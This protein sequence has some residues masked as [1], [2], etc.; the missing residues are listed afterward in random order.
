MALNSCLEFCALCIRWNSSPEVMRLH[1]IF[2]GQKLGINK[3]PRRRMPVMPGLPFTVQ[4][5]I[6]KQHR[7]SGRCYTY[8]SETHSSVG[9]ITPGIWKSKTCSKPPAYN[10]HQSFYLDPS[11][12]TTLMI[13]ISG[14][15]F[16]R[17]VTLQLGPWEFCSNCGF[18]PNPTIV[19]HQVPQNPLI[20]ICNILWS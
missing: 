7:F 3:A 2:L 19:S 20:K 16:Y 12:A 13:G 4:R 11:A 18:F 10:L 17:N 5:A 6:C 14:N 15:L 8:P 1:E 9:I